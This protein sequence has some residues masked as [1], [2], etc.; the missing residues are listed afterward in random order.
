MVLKFVF[1][2]LEGQFRLSVSFMRVRKRQKV[3]DGS[4][5]LYIL[6]TFARLCITHLTTMPFIWNHIPLSNP[7]VGGGAR[8]TIRPLSLPEA[9]ATFK[10]QKF[11]MCNK[12]KAAISLVKNCNTILE[13]EPSS[14]FPIQRTITSSTPPFKTLSPKILSHYFMESAFFQT[15]KRALLLFWV[16]WT[17]K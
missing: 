14:H 11:K 12:A 15:T 6:F 8:H 7:N 13:L 1:Q 2:Q 17:E 9:K 5:L 3:S 4:A 10:F 16:F